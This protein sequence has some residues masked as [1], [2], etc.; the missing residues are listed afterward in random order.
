MKTTLYIQNLKYE[1]CDS[2]ILKML[3]KLKQ[4]YN[5]CDKDE[6]TTSTCVH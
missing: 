1:Y 4:K 2:I 3:Y 5:V 6:Y